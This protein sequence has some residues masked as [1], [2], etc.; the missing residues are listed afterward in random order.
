MSEL[1]I[2]NEANGVYPGVNTPQFTQL[3]YIVSNAKKTNTIIPSLGLFGEASSG[4]TSSAKLIAQAAGYNFLYFNASS[5]S[6]SNFF[7]TITKPVLEIIRKDKSLFIPR[8]RRNANAFVYESTVPFVILIDEA[9]EMN[10]DIQ[11]LF[12]SALQDKDVLNRDEDVSTIGL[13]NITW[14]FATTDSSK[15]LYPLTTRLFSVVFD[16][17]SKEDIMNIVRI[18]HKLISN[19][20]LEIIANCS[21]LVPRVAL[22][23]AEQ[24]SNMHQDKPITEVEVTEFAKNALA[25]EI[26]GID[27]IDKRLLLYLSN[28]KKKIAPVDEIS[29]QAFKEAVARYE[30]KGIANLSNAEHKEYNRAQFNVTVLTHKIATAEFVAKSR[31]DISLACRILDLGDL[32]KR[33]SYLEKLNKITKTPKGVMLHEQYR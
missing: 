27:A 23:Y 31:Q 26:N 5:L 10:K 24:L 18:K 7:K 28:N 25:M 16:Q 22:Q 14:I 21:K 2:F 32:E 9:H 33:L 6:T 13:K 29:L 20:G 8:P 4:K 1:T 19:G 30:K 17:Y 15:L 11:T 3:E 12:L